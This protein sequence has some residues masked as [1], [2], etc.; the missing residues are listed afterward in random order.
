MAS[1]VAPLET[2]SH[3]SREGKH[4]W[5]SPVLHRESDSPVNVTYRIIR[6]LLRLW[7]ALFFRKIRLLEEGF[8]A[9]GPFILVINHPVGFLD[10]L[11]L[12][13]AFERQLH[14]VVDQKS[15]QGP[16]RELFAR[17]LGM[18][19][20]PPAE[21]SRQAAVESCCRLLAQQCAVVLFAEPVHTRDAEPSA[22]ALSV[23]SLALETESRQVGQV[24]MFPVHLFLPVSPS[25]STELL[26][27]VDAPLLARD[28]VSEPDGIASPLAIAKGLDEACRQNVFRLQP[29]N[30]EQLLCELEDALRRDLEDEW[31]QK[32]RWRQ[33][34]EG[35]RLSRLVATA[36]GQMNSLH[37]GGL[38]ALGELLAAYREAQRVAFLR[39][40]ETKRAEWLQSSLLRV[41]TWFETVLGAPIAVYGL[42]NHLLILV[43]LAAGGLLKRRSDWPAA[44]QW[45]VRAAVVLALYVVQVTLC[46]RWLGRA[47]AGYYAVSLPLS[48]AYIWRYWWLVRNRGRLAFFAATL[49]MQTARLQRLRKQLIVDVDAARDKFGVTSMPRVNER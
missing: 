45:A 40:I 14:C 9:T 6:I 8:P 33:K 44:L 3:S 20:Y 11:I 13:A 35:F 15:V 46:A 17:A 47:A 4:V 43:V 39:E 34:V 31:S 18:I 36:A 7:F 1:D 22:F 23:A 19:A 27:Y 38:V 26:I 42:L 48:G 25:T 24:A 21:E 2:L 10:A 30:L 16:I 32:P 41:G 28:Y 29:E 12:V 49:P 37:P 5:S